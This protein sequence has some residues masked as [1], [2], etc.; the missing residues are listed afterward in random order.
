LNRS[1]RLQHFFSIV[2]IILVLALSG[3]GTGCESQIKRQY[4]TLKELRPLT[5]RSPAARQKRIDKTIGIEELMEALADKDSG[6]VMRAASALG[7]TG[8]ERAAPPLIDL[9]SNADPS[10]RFVASEALVKLGPVAVPALIGTLGHKD[11]GVVSAV[12]EILGKIGDKQSVKPLVKALKHQTADSVKLSVASALGAIGGPEVVEP[13]IDILKDRDSVAQF[14]AVESLAEIG[15]VAVTY[16]TAELKNPDQDIVLAVVETLGRTGDPVALPPL[17]ELLDTDPSDAVRMSVVRAMGQLGDPEAVPVL[18]GRLN[19]SVSVVKSIAAEA[20][21][22]IGPASVKP[23]LETLNNRDPETQDLAATALAKIGTPVV[24]PLIERLSVSNARLSW[25]IMDILGNIRDED[26]VDAIIEKLQDADPDVA[27]KAAE[28]LGSIGSES[29]IQPLILQVNSPESL[30]RHAAVEALITIGPPAISPLIEQLSDKDSET[31]NMASDAL[32]RIGTPAIDLLAAKMLSRDAALR[33]TVAEILV[34][35]GT[36]AVEPL[37]VVLAD[38]N[39]AVRMSAA[40]AL[41]KI[42]GPAAVQML[43]NRLSSW[44]ARGTAAETLD[45][46]GWKPE[47][48]IDRTYYFIAKGRREK[49][50]ADWDATR[51]V[52]LKKMQSGSESSRRYAINAF[53]AIGE[54][55]ILPRLIDFLDKMGSEEIAAIYLGSKQADLVEAAKKWLEKLKKDESAPVPTRGAVTW[56]SMGDL[57][58]VK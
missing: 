26:A 56:G 15:K 43:V 40:A 55:S 39:Q 45:V 44:Y 8:S 42:G 7:E 53:I 32:I 30:A 31:R 33:K 48:P 10:L 52:L 19:D 13:L 51:Y 16:L 47:N 3:F 29:A 34:A 57:T 17:I 4:E 2:S 12:A 24:E 6:V 38:R 36:G 37:G 54:N 27:I 21:V 41:V 5:P 1:D 35:A 20:L 23:L 49:L 46:I 50:V 25:T 58:Q 9:L 28:T 14:T 22:R 11:P 18:V